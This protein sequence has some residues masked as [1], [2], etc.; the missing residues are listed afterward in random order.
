[1]R[2]TN[3]LI[4]IMGWLEGRGDRIQYYSGFRSN[5]EIS[6]NGVWMSIWVAT[7]APQRMGAPKEIFILALRRKP[8]CCA[9]GVGS[10]RPLIAVLPNA[11]LGPRRFASIVLVFGSRG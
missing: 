1:M 11:M 2:R 6:G 5:T 3:D 7:L 4:R 8:V 9:V 10:I